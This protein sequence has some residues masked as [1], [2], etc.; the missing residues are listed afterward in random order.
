MRRVGG[1]MVACIGVLLLG[2]LP[3]GAHGT[4]P[5]AANCDAANTS[6]FHGTSDGVGAWT[7]TTSEPTYTPGCDLTIELKKP[8]ATFKGHLLYGESSRWRV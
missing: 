3:A 4:G 8:D 7:I 5:G 1:W 2:V 6:I